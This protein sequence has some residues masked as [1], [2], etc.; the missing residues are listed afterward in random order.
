MQELHKATTVTHGQK[1]LLTGLDICKQVD[2]NWDF[3]QTMLTMDFSIQ[4]GSTLQLVGAQRTL[5]DALLL[6][7]GYVVSDG[8]YK[9]EMGAVAWIIE[10]LTLDVCLIGQWHMPGHGDDH[11]SF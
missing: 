1:I 7:M 6:G 4:W 8:S 11:S 2:H 9:D 5:Q 3:C 10:G